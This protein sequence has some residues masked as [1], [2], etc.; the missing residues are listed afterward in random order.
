M[1]AHGF[2]DLLEVSAI[3][4]GKIIKANHSLIEGE[5]LFYQIA[6]NEAGRAGDQPT[7]GM[8]N[9]MAFDLL[10]FGHDGLQKFL[11]SNGLAEFGGW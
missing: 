3:A 7:V 11:P 6:A 8:A 2:F 1:R 4:G 9:Q 5:Q 10:V